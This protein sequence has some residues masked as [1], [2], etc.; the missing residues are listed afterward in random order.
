MRIKLFHKSL[1]PVFAFVW[2]SFSP[3]PGF[4]VETAPRITDREIVEKLSRLE[5]GQKSIDKRFEDVNKRIDDLRSEMNNRFND[6][7][8]RFSVLQWMFGVFITIALAIFAAI[9]RVLWDQNR[10][11]AAHEKIIQNLSGEIESL[12]QTD[13]KLMDQIRAL[14]EALKPPRG[15]L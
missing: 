4:A 10:S 14:I 9:A 6:L 3:N 5:E 15:V 2:L 7:N 12:K 13:L 1:F 8:Q 11:R